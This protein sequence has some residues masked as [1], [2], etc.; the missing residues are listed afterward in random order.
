VFLG[1]VV[2]V[3]VVEVVPVELEPVVVVVVEEEVPPFSTFPSFTDTSPAVPQ[4]IIV[5]NAIIAKNFLIG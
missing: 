4:D 2:V 3:V 5:A 1:E